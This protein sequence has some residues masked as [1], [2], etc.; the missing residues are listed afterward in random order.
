VDPSLRDEKKRIQ[1]FNE[2][3][4]ETFSLSFTNCDAPWATKALDD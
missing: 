2:M 1:S 3:D 4:S